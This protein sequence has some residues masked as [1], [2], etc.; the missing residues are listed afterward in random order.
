MKPCWRVWRVQTDFGEWTDAVSVVL[1][2]ISTSKYEF[3]MLYKAARGSSSSK[4]VSYP[5]R[6]GS[7]WIPAESQELVRGR[8]QQGQCYHSR[9]GF[10]VKQFI[11]TWKWLTP[12]QNRVYMGLQSNRFCLTYVKSCEQQ[13]K[14]Y[15]LL[16][17][18]SSEERRT[19]AQQMRAL[20]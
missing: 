7:M 18:S 13:S 6:R 20:C 5:E 19:K 3:Q 16:P 11:S 2:T 8:V 9:V 10:S 15:S 1:S 12:L 17:P 4:E 14:L